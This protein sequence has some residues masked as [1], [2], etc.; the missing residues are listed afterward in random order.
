M[1][2]SSSGS[3]HVAIAARASPRYAASAIEI[4]MGQCPCAL[5][6]LGQVDEVAAAF[7]APPLATAGD[8][9]AMPWSGKL[10]LRQGWPQ[11]WSR[12]STIT[13]PPS[14][15]PTPTV[16]PTM[17]TVAC[18]SFVG[19][20]GSAGNGAGEFFDPEAIAVDPGGNVYVADTGNHRIQK[21]AATGS[22]LLQ[23]G[24]MGSANGQFHSPEGIAA[25]GAGNVF[26]TDLAPAAATRSS[27]AP[28]PLTQTPTSSWWT[29]ATS[30]SRSSPTLGVFSPSG[31]ARA[32]TT[33]SSIPRRP[34]QW[35]RTMKIVV[36]DEGNRVQRYA[37]PLSSTIVRRSRSQQEFDSQTSAR[38]SKEIR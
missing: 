15:T 5:L 25:D 36:T 3:S 2:H 11:V 33:D 4:T 27:S 37:C 13:H 32:S 30:G 19:E 1:R 23:W 35:L 16:T 7:V 22:F 9:P 21:F 8:G 38:L 20:F 34:S 26:V 31:A 28:L 29:T 12:S 18:G 10:R 6:G 17:V 14:T 24:S